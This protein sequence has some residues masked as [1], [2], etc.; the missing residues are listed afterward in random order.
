MTT[1]MLKLGPAI[2]V[3]AELA[4]DAAWER[5][6]LSLLTR[7]AGFARLVNF[8]IDADFCRRSPLTHAAPGHECDGC[9]CVRPG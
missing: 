9:G 8:A 3:L 4:N 5:K 7:P 1:F 6:V 2:E